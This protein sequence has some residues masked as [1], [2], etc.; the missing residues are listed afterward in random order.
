M[1]MPYAFWA[2]WTTAVVLAEDVAAAV[3]LMVPVLVFVSVPARSPVMYMA[4]APLAD[5]VPLTLATIS[6]ELARDP[7]R[8]PLYPTAVA[9]DVPAAET[10]APVRLIMLVPVAPA[11]VSTPMARD[12]APK[13]AR[14]R[15]LLSMTTPVPPPST[16]TAS[17]VP[18]VT[19]ILPLLVTVSRSVAVKP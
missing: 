2:L 8:E 13:S 15:P 3:A 14:I 4:V 17:V 5:V 7:T 1:Y 6:P 12:A 19:S 18:D 11:V 9:E 10:S 16:P